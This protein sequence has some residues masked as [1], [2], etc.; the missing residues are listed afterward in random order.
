MPGMLAWMV[1]GVTRCVYVPWVCTHA[2]VCCVPEGFL[3]SARA[4]LPVGCIFLH[5]SHAHMYIA[6]ADMQ[7]PG[8]YP[9]HRP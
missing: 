7:I 2:S 9:D 3:G 4:R 1:W 8:L 5:M 6:V